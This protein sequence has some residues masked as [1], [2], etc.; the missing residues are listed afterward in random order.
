MFTL[1]Y[2]CIAM[3]GT[4]DAPGLVWEFT[5]ESPALWLLAGQ[6]RV[7]AA[8]RLR[9]R[10]TSL[11]RYLERVSGPLYRYIALSGTTDAPRSVRMSLLR[12]GCLR[13]ASDYAFAPAGYIA[14]PLFKSVCAI[15]R[16]L[17]CGQI[18]R[19]ASVGEGAHG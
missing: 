4:T 19:C 5:D 7:L 18:K 8:T 1:L 17:S 6:A 12:C 3:S 2:R 16:M 14:A 10:A 15:E 9:L 11:R 13:V